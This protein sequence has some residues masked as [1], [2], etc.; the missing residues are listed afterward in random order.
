MDACES[1]GAADHVCGTRERGEARLRA[2]DHL[3]VW[4][5]L[6]WHHG[7]YAGGGRVV[8][9]ANWFHGGVVRVV[10]FERFVRGRA[11]ETVEDNGGLDAAD[12]VARALG[13]VGEPGYDVL[14]NNCEH[15]A[16]WCRTGRA[17]SRQVGR[18]KRAAVVG[19][20]TGAA[21]LTL[22]AKARGRRA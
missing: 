3:R 14:F 11:V 4:T 7:I 5:G 18:V 13:R 19:L 12:V 21:A 2:G 8:E 1:S 9:Y 20:V 10:E 22:A 16:T 17:Q 15:F 6:Y